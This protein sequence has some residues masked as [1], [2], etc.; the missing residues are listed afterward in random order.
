MLGGDLLIPPSTVLRG[1]TTQFSYDD[2]GNLVKKIKPDGN[3]TLYVGGIYEIDKTSGGSITHMVTYY[4][5]AG[6]MSIDS[7]L[8]YM[9]KDH[10]GSASV[11]TNAS[12]NILG[13]QRYYPFGSKRLTM[14][15]IYK[16]K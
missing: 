14:G 3:K 7:T 16:D 5:F 2:D 1:Q 11:V 15:T 4:P 6:A 10:L 8:Y 9:L 13:G 12:R